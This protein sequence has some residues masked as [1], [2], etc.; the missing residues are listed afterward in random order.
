M[1]QSCILLPLPRRLCSRQCLSVCLSVCLL[2]G[3][4]CNN[5]QELFMKPCRIMDYCY[6]KNPLNFQ[7]NSIENDQMAAILDFRHNI[8]HI[9]NFDRHSA[10][11]ASILHMVY[12]TVC[13]T[14]QGRLFPYWQWC[15][16]LS[17]HLNLV[18]LGVVCSPI[19][20]YVAWY[21]QGRFWDYVRLMLS[22]Y[23]TTRCEMPVSFSTRVSS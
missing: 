12:C 17:T 3:K 4:L 6:G 22:Y 19:R 21:C 18:S 8:L 7:V 15:T 11:G 9:I 2:L 14:E 13:N 1:F 16:Q 23:N 20:V 10:G 5:F